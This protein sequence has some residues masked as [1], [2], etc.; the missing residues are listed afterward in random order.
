MKEG[1]SLLRN[2]KG[3]P[4]IIYNYSKFYNILSLILGDNPFNDSNCF[5]IYINPETF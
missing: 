2:H 3:K 5:R 1:L 4:F